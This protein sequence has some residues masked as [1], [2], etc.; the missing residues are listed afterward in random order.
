MFIDMEGTPVQELS[1]LMMDIKQECIIAAYH[2]HAYCSPT[3]DRWCRSNIHG[4]D[5][6]VLKEIGFPNEDE[7]FND[8]KIWFQK[9]THVEKAYANNPRK[10]TRFLSIPVTDIELP[11]WSE[12]VKFMY[13]NIPNRFKEDNQSLFMN[14]NIICNTKYHGLFSPSR[15]RCRTPCQV[16]K[17]KASHHC[18]LADVSEL[19]LYYH[20]RK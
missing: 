12:R 1:A 13:H 11:V 18:S 9:F 8:F 10:E 17:S 14:I 20:F 7:L 3:M 16:A 4:L 19:F 6:D 15:V 2:R 5:P